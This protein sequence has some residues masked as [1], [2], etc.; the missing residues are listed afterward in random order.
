MS[1]PHPSFVKICPETASF[2][3]MT[4]LIATIHRRAHCCQISQRQQRYSSCAAV[5][6]DAR[7]LSL[8]FQIMAG[9]LRSCGAWN[10]DSVIS[11]LV[12]LFVHLKKIFNLS[13]YNVSIISRSL[14]PANCA[15]RSLRL[16]RARRETVNTSSPFTSASLSRI[17]FAPSRICTLISL[18]SLSTGESAIT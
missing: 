17:S 18:S 8:T 12:S 7:P 2:H 1:V 13:R 6:C 11:F 16:S 9:V 10:V 4:K 14:P 3:R 5:L 15:I